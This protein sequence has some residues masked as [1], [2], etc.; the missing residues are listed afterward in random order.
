M[1]AH[2]EEFNYLEG[3]PLEQEEECLICCSK[4]PTFIECQ[5]CSKMICVECMTTDLKT[6]FKMRCPFCLKVFLEIS[7]GYFIEQGVTNTI[8][9]HSL[10][11]CNAH[12]SAITTKVRTKVSI[13][14]EIDEMMEKGFGDDL[15]QQILRNA[16]NEAKKK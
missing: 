9:L 2:S 13:K 8:H 12:C 3:T 5:R 7:K 4:Q 11:V 6:T 14:S 1:I 16:F 10:M 15:I